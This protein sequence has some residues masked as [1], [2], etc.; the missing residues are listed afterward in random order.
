MLRSFAPPDPDHAIGRKPHR[1]G[2]RAEAVPYQEKLDGYE[3]LRYRRLRM[4]S[5]RAAFAPLSIFDGSA[6]P[7]SVD[8]SSLHEGQRLAKPGLPGFSSNSSP[9]TTQ[10]LMK[11]ATFSLYEPK[12]GQMKYARRFLRAR[13]VA[14]LLQSLPRPAQVKSSTLRKPSL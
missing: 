6:D 4:A 14:L 10:V 8:S 12:D 9:Q 7:E 2:T 1:P 5:R 3:S 13:E 11:Y